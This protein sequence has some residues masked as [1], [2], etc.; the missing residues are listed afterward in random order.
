MPR[1]PTFRKNVGIIWQRKIQRDFRNSETTGKCIEAR[2]LIIMLP[3]SLIEYDHE[4]S[5]TE[6]FSKRFNMF[7]REIV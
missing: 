7:S 5:T 2:K 1:V 6:T 4:A 3:P